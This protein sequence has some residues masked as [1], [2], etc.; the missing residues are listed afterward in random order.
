M[1]L[2]DGTTARH[3]R[4]RLNKSP[5]D[6]AEGCGMEPKTLA[7][8]EAGKGRV[9]CS[10]EKAYPLAEQLGVELLV[11]LIDE[12]DKREYRRTKAAIEDASAEAATETPAEDT[13]ETVV[14]AQAETADRV[15]S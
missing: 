13:S 3:L 6:V 2:I 12:D 10:W 15:A 11:L 8:I 5:E 14:A 9:G 7:N 1:P 4:A